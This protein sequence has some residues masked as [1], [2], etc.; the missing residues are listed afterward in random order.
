MPSGSRSGLIVK[1]LSRHLIFTASLFA[2]ASDAAVLPASPFAD[3]MVLQRGMRVPVWGTAQ[4]GEVVTVSFAGQTKR[5]FADTNGCWSV[6][7]DPMEASWGP[8]V[9]VAG[10][11][12]EFHPAY[13]ANT[14]IEKGRKGTLYEGRE[15]IV[16][17]DKVKTPKR[18][19]YLYSKPWIGSLYS[20][21][22]G[23]PLGPFE[24]NVEPC[25]NEE[26]YADLW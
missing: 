11:D 20:E 24:V 14:L 23:L 19:R 5:C 9:L 13:V 22:S 16:A 4:P 1:K 15:L 21:D 8:R 26:T 7:L 12:G 25:R 18:L 2:I 17:S 6:C 3:N 10:D